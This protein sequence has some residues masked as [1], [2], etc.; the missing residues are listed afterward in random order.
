MTKNILMKGEYVIHRYED[1]PTADY[2]NGGE[3]KGYV[4]EAVVGF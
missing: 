1:F 3:F 2:R 4:I